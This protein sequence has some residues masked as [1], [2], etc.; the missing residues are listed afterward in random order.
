MNLR[1]LLFDG[2]DDTLHAFDVGIDSGAITGSPGLVNARWSI[3]AASCGGC[4]PH[5]SL[6]TQD[7]IRC[8]F[9]WSKFVLL[10]QMERHVF[11]ELI[12]DHDGVSMSVHR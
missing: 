9:I 6:R 3:P 4:R 5:A 11:E 12:N 10:Q 7:H 1:S 8:P 2:L